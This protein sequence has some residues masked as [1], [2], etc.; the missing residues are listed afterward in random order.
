MTPLS[1]Q[2]VALQTTLRAS[3][4]EKLCYAQEL[5]GHQIP[6]GDIDRLLDKLLDLDHS[7]VPW[8]RALGF[9][10]AEARRAAERCEH[11]PDASLE[12]R[13]RAALS[14]FRGR[15]SHSVPAPS[16]A[17]VPAIAG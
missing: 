4:H 6:S 9:S 15:G 5:L 10:A 16:Q 2:S 1:S 11:V 7:V 13:V 17:G 3:T 8:L 14:T 12:E